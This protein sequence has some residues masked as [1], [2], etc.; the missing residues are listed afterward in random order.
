MTF[1]VSIVQRMMFT[2]AIV[3]R[4]TFTN[5]QSYN[6]LHLKLYKTEQITYTL[7]NA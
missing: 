3:Q 1:T 6:I 7:H 4:I 5:I 2:I